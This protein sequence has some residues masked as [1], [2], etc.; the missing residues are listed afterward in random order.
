M[1]INHSSSFALA[2]CLLCNARD[3]VHATLILPS[4]LQLPQIQSSWNY[5]F[6]QL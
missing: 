4:V 3:C 1:G 2:A 6:Q 5:L